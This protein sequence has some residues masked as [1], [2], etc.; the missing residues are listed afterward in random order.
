M[1]VLDRLDDAWVRVERGVVALMLAVMGVVVFLDVLHRMSTRAGSVFANP[2]AV[3]VLGGGVGILALRTRGATHAVAKGALL[4]VALAGGQLA[5]VHFVPNGMV[6][7]QTVALALTLWLG[8]MGASIAAHQRRHL[9]LDIGSKLWPAWLAPKI[10]AL[11]HL[12]TAVF[13]AAVLVLAWRSLFGYEVGG[14]H[15]DGHIGAWVNSQHAA[16]VL[17]GTAIPKWA[18]MAAIPYGM[19]VLTVRFSLEAAR[20]WTGRVAVGGDDT[21]HL[22]G[23]EEA[24]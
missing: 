14:A 24:S 16:G 12:C 11:G 18:A 13:C 4:G 3:A 15:V 22:L 9:A 6:W 7:S 2:F 21:L 17:T 8:T 10:A 19:A 1:P 20:T 5:L 23:I